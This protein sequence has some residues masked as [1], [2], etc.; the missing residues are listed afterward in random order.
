MRNPLRS[1][2][3]AFR[4]LGIVIAGAIVIVGAA[5]ANTW[6]GVA[7]ALVVVGAVAWWLLRSPS[8]ERPPPRLTSSSPEEG[9]HRILVV[10]NETVGGG[11]LRDEVT[12]RAGGR[13]TEVL[14]VAPALN[15]RVRHWAS[16]DDHARAAAQTRVQASVERL[17]QT[18]LEVRGEVGDGDP[19]QAI[20]DALRI[21]GADE[22]VIS[23]HPE[24]RSHWL[25]QHLIER[26]RDH[27]ALPLSHVVVDLEREHEEIRG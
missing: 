6:V 4:F 22:I 8:G 5:Y 7:A 11:A 12:R 17:G 2:P 16:D 26:A 23:T 19:M 9:V 3:E 18:G 27:F 14:V 13:R 10:A 15:S 24:G 21:F 20:E 25:E 1:E